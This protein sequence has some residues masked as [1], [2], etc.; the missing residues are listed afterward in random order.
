[1]R[2]EE[3]LN[4]AYDIKSGGFM[5]P[6]LAVQ[7][8]VENAVQPIVE[9]AVRPIV[10]NAVRHG[11]TKK[12][13]G[14]TVTVSVGETETAYTINVSDTGVRFDPERRSRRR[15]PYRHPQRQG[16]SCADVRRL[17]GDL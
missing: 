2:F 10:E 13:E 6:P 8:I 15:L 1:M 3:R 14:G 16:A 12:P 4:V 11:V 5:I 9:N 17:A 7:P